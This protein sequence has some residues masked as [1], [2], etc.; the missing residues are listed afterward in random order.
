MMV[1]SPY[2]SGQNGSM[3]PPYPS[4][5]DDHHPRPQ[6]KKGKGK[7]YKGGRGG[8]DGFNDEYE[9]LDSSTNPATPYG[10][11]GWYP[12]A[13][14][15]PG[16]ADNGYTRNGPDPYPYIPKFENPQ[17]YNNNG[18]Y[19]NNNGFHANSHGN[20]YGNGN[21]NGNEFSNGFGNGNGKGSYRSKKGKN[22][23]NEQGRLHLKPEFNNKRGPRNDAFDFAPP[24]AAGG[25]PPM[26]LYAPS[27]GQQEFPT[28]GGTQS[29]GHQHGTSITS[30]RTV[31][32]GNY[33][34]AAG[35]YNG[36]A[37]GMAGPTKGYISRQGG[38][39]DETKG[40]EW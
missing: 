20:G 28:L 8:R 31:K 38:A 22:W 16:L 9:Y 14:G 5:A 26:S 29:F 7:K 25:V 39:Y 12:Q 15:D 13:R 24:G 37:G 18:Y 36:N 40:M 32:V 35:G 30:D 6:G 10:S 1:D 3:P 23:N 2:P 17:D 33:A 27:P 4:V 19:Q 11:A 21:G 34:A